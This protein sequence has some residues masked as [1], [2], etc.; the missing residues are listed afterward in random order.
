L[1]VDRIAIYDRCDKADEFV[2]AKSFGI[3]YN[4]SLDLSF[5]VVER[6]EQYAGHIFFDNTRKAFA[7]KRGCAGNHRQAEP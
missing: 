6:P 3:S 1:L 2:M 4:G 7:G 5:L